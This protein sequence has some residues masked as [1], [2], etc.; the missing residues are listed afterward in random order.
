MAAGIASYLLPE[1]GQLGEHRCPRSHRLD[2]QQERH[3]VAPQH[4]E[5]T[6]L[7]ASPKIQL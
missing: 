4:A 2:L 1:G 6:G 7:T 3:A 5:T